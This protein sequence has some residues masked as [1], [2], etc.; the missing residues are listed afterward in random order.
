MLKNY[1]VILGIPTDASLEQIRS[2]YRQQVKELHP[3]HYGEDSG[4]FREVQEAYK[5]LSDSER[6]R[7]YDRDLQKQQQRH[8]GNVGRTPDPFGSAPIEEVTPS[9]RP[10]VEEVFEHPPRAQRAQSVEEAF[11]E[12]LDRFF[13]FF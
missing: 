2:A 11:Q 13:R 10:V 4:P 12:L 9:R 1:Y 8:R 6:R 5:V 3:D 7:N